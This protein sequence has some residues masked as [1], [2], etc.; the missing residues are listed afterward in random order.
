MAA[1]WQHA[2]GETTDS[3]RNQTP[4]KNPKDESV[5]FP[6]VIRYIAFDF[7]VQLATAR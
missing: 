6:N 5:C 4:K 2:L 1:L 7:S 3:Y